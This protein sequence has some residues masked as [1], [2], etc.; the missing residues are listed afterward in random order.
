MQNSLVKKYGLNHMRKIARKGGRTTVELYG[1]RFMSLIAS[2]KNTNLSKAREL[3]IRRA[4]RK[5]LDV[6]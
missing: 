3:R 2:L 4:I 6:Y 1:T 5:I